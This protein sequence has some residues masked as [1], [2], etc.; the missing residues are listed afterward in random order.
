MLSTAADKAWAQPAA[1]GYNVERNHWSMD[2]Y[3]IYTCT[4]IYNSTAA[5]SMASYE[6]YECDTARDSTSAHTKSLTKYGQQN[7]SE[8]RQNWLFFIYFYKHIFCNCQCFHPW[9]YMTTLS[10]GLKVK[11]KIGF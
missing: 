11:L 9:C 5:D 7:V 6:H 8:V 10:Y 4:V 2:N 1:P 3:L